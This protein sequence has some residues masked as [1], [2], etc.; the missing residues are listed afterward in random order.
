MFH[1]AE[2]ITQFVDPARLGHAAGDP[3]KF[4]KGRHGLTRR[5]GIGRLGIIDETDMSDAADFLHPVR[6]PWEGA[7]S[8]DDLVHLQ[9][10]RLAGRIGGGGVLPVMTAGQGTHGFEIDHLAGADIGAIIKHAV[11]RIDAVAEGTA[12]RD[13]DQLHR[14]IDAH[15]AD[16]GR[17]IVIVRT[18][19]S[20]LL[21]ALRHEDAPLGL[22]ITFHAAVAIKV[23]R[24][25]IHQHRHIR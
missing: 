10:Q 23:I 16:N 20:G 15:I 25:D 13:R 5:I 3:V 24:R 12:R 18:N 14:R 4:V 19:H 11:Q 21:R 8:G 2:Q 1:P 17:C 22:D 9:P 6:Q 7:H